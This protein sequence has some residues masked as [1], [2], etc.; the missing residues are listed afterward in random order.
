MKIKFLLLLLFSIAC[1]RT[2]DARAD[3]Y[4]SPPL[5]K[6]FFEIGYKPVEEALNLCEDHFQQ[7][8][9]LPY[10]LPPISFTHYLGRCTNNLGASNGFEV[11][12]LN[13]E[14]PELHYMLHIRPKE[15]GLKVNREHIEKTF[16]LNDGQGIYVTK[17]IRSFNLFIFERDGWQYILSIDKRVSR[18]VPPEVLA[19]I[20]NSFR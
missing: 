7:Q 11:E 9:V 2:G 3:N 20:A 4:D 17:L 14:L 18:Q 6:G 13:E 8:I 10:K 1:F 19:D 12:F 16:K 5:E 15:Y